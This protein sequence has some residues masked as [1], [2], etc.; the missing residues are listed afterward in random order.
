M[1]QELYVLIYDLDMSKL[2]S[3]NKKVLFDYDIIDKFEA[4]IIL[5]GWEVKS[6]KA[7][8]FNIKGSFVKE[9]NNEIF[10]MN[11]G[12][13]AWKFSLQR[14]KD[15]ENRPRKLL[16][17]KGEIKKVIENTKIPGLTAVPF[18]VIISD[19]GLV[20]IIIAVVR[21]RKKYDKREKLKAKDLVRRVA[22][23]R[24][25]YNF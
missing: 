4:G 16:L 17:N 12:I 24:K 18:E 8:H 2:I 7:G 6:V 20:K 19:N 21:G 25:K 23:D 5:Q 3:S 11:S 9:N 22:E 1:E 14:S 13:P 15:E 10:L